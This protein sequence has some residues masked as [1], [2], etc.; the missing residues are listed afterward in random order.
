MYRGSEIEKLDQSIATRSERYAATL[1][2][3]ESQSW[4]LDDLVEDAGSVD[5]EDEADNLKPLE[6]FPAKAEAHEP[7]E[8]GA[9]GVDS[10]ACSGGDRAG[11]TEAEEVEATVQVS[12]K[13]SVQ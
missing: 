4:W 10:T 13:H 7:D 12:Q 8:E 2:P 3:Q 9:A 11:D 5:E 1:F 6:G